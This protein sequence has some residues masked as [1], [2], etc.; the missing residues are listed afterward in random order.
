MS[1]IA[2]LLAGK[3]DDRIIM[4]ECDAPRESGLRHFKLGAPPT[5][6]I[7]RERERRHRRMRIFDASMR[8]NTCPLQNGPITVEG[9]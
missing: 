1:A 4:G 8:P 6:E 7:E 5:P 3:D 9:K 2:S